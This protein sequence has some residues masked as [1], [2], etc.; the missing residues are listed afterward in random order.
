MLSIIFFGLWSVM[1]AVILGAVLTGPNLN[2]WTKKQ[3]ILAIIV[4]GPI[5]WVCGII[6]GVM[7]AFIWLWY[8][9]G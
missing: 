8:K 2:R 5:A 4:A 1:G 3:F 6:T 9:L 7:Q